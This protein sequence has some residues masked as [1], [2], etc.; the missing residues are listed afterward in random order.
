[1]ENIIL[2]VI[3]D[4]LLVFLIVLILICLPIYYGSCREARV[5]NQINGT[6][7]TCSD[8]FWASEQINQQTQTIK[9]EK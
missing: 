8:F 9:I 1:M 4:T 7:Y 3:R 5:Y 2:E 6:N